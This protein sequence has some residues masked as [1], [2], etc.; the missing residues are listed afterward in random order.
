MR[1]HAIASSFIAIFVVVLI[2]SAAL[3]VSTSTVAVTKHFV[4]GSI[5]S[6]GSPGTAATSFTSQAPKVCSYVQLSSRANGQQI[7]WKFIN[8]PQNALYMQG[9]V[10]ISIGFNGAWSCITIAGKAAAKLPGPWS[11]Q[12]WYGGS[13]LF[14]D[15]FTITSAADSDSVTPSPNG[16]RIVRHVMARDVT[17]S[18][19]CTP[20]TTTSFS[21]QDS[22]AISFIELSGSYQGKRLKWEFYD[23]TG[24]LY[25]TTEADAISRYHWAWFNLSGHP[26][27]A[28]GGQ[29]STE[30]YVN[31]QLQFKDTFTIAAASAASI[32]PAS[33][34][35]VT[36]SSLG[37][38]SSR[39]ILSIDGKGDESARLQVFDS[40]GRLV[41]NGDFQP[42][43]RLSWNGLDASGRRLANGVYLYWVTARNGDGK[44]VK[45]EIKKLVVKR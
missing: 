10:T 44:V 27:A 42:G 14:S 36:L 26:A 43:S 45:S 1:L 33:I 2:Q 40:H 20:L 28:R 9:N 8:P 22:R 7:T 12:L 3:A 15:P 5:S 17:K 6:N 18:P 31:G 24:N 13:M 30:F 21:S 41:Y 4:T 29:W 23:P 34:Q 37:A 32:Q 19:C 39:Y 16:F 11:V 25:A 35:N 38:H